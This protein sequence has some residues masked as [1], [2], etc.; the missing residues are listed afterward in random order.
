MKPLR[1]A[2]T[3]RATSVAGA[4][5]WTIRENGHVEM[6]A[7]GAAAVNQATKAV[8]IARTYLAAEGIDL[9]MIPVFTTVTIS[10]EDRTALRFIVQPR[11]A[12]TPDEL[13]QQGEVPPL[14]IAA[15]A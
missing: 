15:S 7:V 5:A 2:K 8:A 11:E 9:I 13:K 14:E 10:D 3:S 1:V 6:E 12:E 4:I